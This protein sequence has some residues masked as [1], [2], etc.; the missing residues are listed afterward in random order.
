MK[1]QQQLSEFKKHIGYDH[2]VNENNQLMVRRELAPIAEVGSTGGYKIGN[3]DF[4]PS[5][6]GD[7]L[8]FTIDR[9]NKEISIDSEESFK[10]TDFESLSAEE[11][12]I[13]VENTFVFHTTVS[14]ENVSAGESGGWD[15]PD[16]HDELE[17]ELSPE[18]EKMI[19]YKLLDPT[20][21]DHIR[22]EEASVISDYV[23]G[24]LYGRK[25]FDKQKSSHHYMNDDGG[26]ES[27]DNDFVDFGDYGDNK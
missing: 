12:G 20:K 21:K 4:E 27:Y 13:D 11:G 2:M 16:T 5:G 25:Y 3:V 17:I 10:D 24:E 19:G 9:T 7:L 23:Y 15:H 14:S 22:P 18:I 26:D 8:V 6:K 1:K